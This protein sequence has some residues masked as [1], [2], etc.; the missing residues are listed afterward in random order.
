VGAHVRIPGGIIM[1]EQEAAPEAVIRAEPS[2]APALLLA[3]LS[4]GAGVLHLVMAPIHASGSGVE[5]AGFALAG[6]LQLALAAFLL[7][8]PA[9]AVLTATA[10][11]N[12]IFI[13]VWVMSRTVG[14]PV[15]HEAWV[16]ESVGSADLATVILEALAVALAVTLILRPGFLSGLSR[17]AAAMLALVPLAAL[18]VVTMVVVSPTTAQHD[19]G[20]GATGQPIAAALNAEQSRCDRGFN[21]K[22]YWGEAAKAGVDTGERAA[23]APD[24]TGAMAGMDH[25]GDD[26]GNAATTPAAAAPTTTMPDPLA[27]RGSKKLDSVV[28]KLSSAS[29]ADA[30]AVVVALADFSDQEYDG[31]L[32]QL[33]KNG[34]A[35]AAH[36]ATGDDTGGH[37][38]H[39]GPS[40]WVPMTDKAQCDQLAQELTIARDT[41]LKYPTAADAQAGGWQKVT[42]YV[43]GI[44]AHYMNFKY[45]DG[46]FEVDKPEMLLYDGNGPE[47][48]V[49]GVSYYIMQAGDN[50][51][52][53]GFTGDND[54]GHRHIGLCMK[55]G[56]VIGPSTMTAD[57][58][59][60]AGGTKAGGQAGWMSHAW[61]IPGCES[62][63]GVFS[64]ASPV[65]DGQL[66]AQSGKNDGGC[67]GSKAKARY[68]LSPGTVPAA[69]PASGTENA[70]GR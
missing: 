41:A 62:P 22:A 66:S 19:H 23:A 30:A 37:G 2:F 28:S 70:A 4:A 8:R 15:G 40:P 24:A 61:V 68:D 42:P 9:R 53:Q 25:G 60:A 35:H 55:G 56:V 69:A 7:V 47:A 45:V 16:A 14:L 44:A 59:A 34:A 64:G 49:A 43:P 58:C 67:A 1:V 32:Y 20:S 3:T 29:E 18:L 38:G 5:A 13:L 57:D 17:E 39:M 65:L 63:W 50:E 48:H 11:A 12:G 36:A 21:P 51:P 33:R 54:H 6:W 52:T 46:T 10:A 31:F 26:H 27:G